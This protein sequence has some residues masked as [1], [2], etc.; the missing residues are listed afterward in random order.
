[1]K[2]DGVGE[3]MNERTK[4]NCILRRRRRTKIYFINLKGNCN[5]LAIVITMILGQFSCF[6]LKVNFCI[7]YLQCFKILKQYKR[8]VLYIRVTYLQ[9]GDYKMYYC[10]KV[11]TTF[12]CYLY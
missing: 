2:Q 12:I 10:T 3:R 11:T 5:D 1:M 4:T 6:R 8:G 9:Y 7:K